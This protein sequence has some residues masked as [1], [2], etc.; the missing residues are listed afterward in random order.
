MTLHVRAGYTRLRI[1]PGNDAK[2]L[3]Y[4]TM[5]FHAIIDGASGVG[6]EADERRRSLTLRLADGS[7]Q[8]WLPVPGTIVC[9]GP[10]MR[11]VEFGETLIEMTL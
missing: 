8:G 3:S 6:I 2:F 1:S 5:A 9:D 7:L 4:E 10:R 11:R